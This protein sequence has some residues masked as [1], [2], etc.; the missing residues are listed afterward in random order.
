MTTVLTNFLQTSKVRWSCMGCSA[1][2][3]VECFT[4]GGHKQGQVTRTLMSQV[5]TML[6]QVLS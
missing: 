5:G 1:C 4:I 3:K 2:S 6:Q